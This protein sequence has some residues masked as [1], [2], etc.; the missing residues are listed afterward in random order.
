VGRL[1]ASVDRSVGAGL[2]DWSR[3][4][5]IYTHAH[6]EVGTCQMLWSSK[7]SSKHGR[8]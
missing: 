5:D 3:T 1:V 8:R 7:P 6:N 2:L 4:L